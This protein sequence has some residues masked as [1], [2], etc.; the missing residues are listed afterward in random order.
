MPSHDGGVSGE[1]YA[2]DRGPAVRARFFEEANDSNLRRTAELTEQMT[3]LEATM[4]EMASIQTDYNEGVD[5]TMTSVIRL[6]GKQEEQEESTRKLK[7][8]FDAS[9]NRASSSPDRKDKTV[10]ITNLN[11]F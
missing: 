7:E 10:M 9:F 1:D 11:G 6:E 2:A 5:K 4:A 8:E 3:Q